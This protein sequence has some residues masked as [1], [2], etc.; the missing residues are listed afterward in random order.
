MDDSAECRYDM[1]LGR[2]VLTALG[3][4]IKISDHTIK[5]GVRPYQGDMVSM[6]DPNYYDFKPIN[7]TKNYTGRIFMGA[8]IEEC[9]E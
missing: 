7:K 5:V 6:V 1:I 2:N 8:Y 4:D 9:F 3:I